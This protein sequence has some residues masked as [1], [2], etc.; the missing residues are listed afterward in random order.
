MQPVKP[1]NNVKKKRRIGN[2]VRNKLYD[3]CPFFNDC[4][5]ALNCSLLN[6]SFQ[7]A[8][9]SCE[10]VGGVSESCEQEL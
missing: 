3:F 1:L 5:V 7:V 2:K 9:E 6:R 10:Q 4:K 8:S